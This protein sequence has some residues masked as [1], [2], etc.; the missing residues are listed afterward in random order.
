MSNGKV[1]AFGKLGRLITKRKWVVI[2][3]WLLLLAII[4]PVVVTASGYTSLTFNASTDT[5][6]ESGKANDIIA[7]QFKSAVSNDS[8]ILVVST[9]NASSIETQKF[10]DDL[11]N[12]IKSDSSIT[13]IENV[14][15][16][17]AILIPA[18]NQTNQGVYLAYNNG[19]LTYNLLYAVP[20]VYS[21]VWY[22]AYTTALNDNLVPGLSQTNQGVYQLIPNAN[23]T[24]TL[25]YSVPT[26]YST[27]YANAY[28]QTR[29][30]MLAPGL[31]QANAGVYTA[32]ENANL[33][34]NML[35]STPAIYLNVWGQT[36]A[37]TSDINQANTV[38]NQTTAETLYAADPIS[39][40]MYTSHLLEAFHTYWTTSFSDPGTASWTPQYRA[41]YASNQTNQLY[42]STYL[43]SN[44]TEQAFVTAVTNTFSLEDYLANN[45][46]ATNAKLVGFGI[47]TVTAAS[48]GQS[49]IEFITAAYNLGSNPTNAQLTALAEDLIQ[50]PTAYNM[51]TDFI[52][53]FNDVAFNQTQ[54]ILQ[55]A[56]PTSYAQYTGP[57]LAAF[58]N[59]W[60]LSYQN[61][62][63]QSLTVFERAALVS[64]MTNK[65]YIDTAF[66]SDPTSKAFATALIQNFTLTDFMTNTQAQN[67]AKILD[68]SIKY[69]A[70]QG[71]VS[72]QFVWAAYNLG[73]SP[74]NSALKDLA[75]NI[76]WHPSS[77]GMT[78]DFIST[79][80][81]V[82]YDQTKT[83]LRDADRESFQNYTSHLLDN[84]NSAWAAR[85][86]NTPGSSWINSTAA[87]ASSVANAKFINDYFSDN[88]DFANAVG[89]TFSLQ[90]YL[91][92]NTTKSNAKLYDF[93]IN[94][95]ANE[96]GMSKELLAAVYKLGENAT[97]TSLQTLASNILWNPDAYGIGE[98]LNT[99]V[100][101]FVSPTQ[102]VTLISVS[103]NETNVDNVQ[104]IRNDI[105][106]LLNQDTGAVSSVKVTGEDAISQD[107]M[108]S[109]NSDLDLILPITIA[110]LVIATGLFFRSI[111]TPIV[112]LGTI[113][114]GL[115]VSMVF[116]YLIGT[117]IN[118]V[119]YTTVTVLLTVLIGVGT[120]YSI[121]V[122]ARHREERINGLPLAEAIKKSVTWAGESIVTSGTT[123]IIS[124]LALA[125]TSM[126]MLQTMGLIV[127][128]G[129]I[130]TL[131][132]SLT[133]APALTAILGDRIFWPNSGK[134]F[135]RYSKAI[136][137]KNNR[138]GGYFAKS[139]NFSVKH[140][141]AIILVAIL[142]TVPTFYVYAT[143]TQTFDIIGSAS[144]RL[145]SISGM[146]TL[147]DSFGGGRMLPSYVVVTFSEPILY[148]NGSFNQNEM[149]TLSEISSYIGSH[150]GVDKVT[151]PTMPF[152]VAVDY[153]TITN[154][155]DSTTY[156]S[157]IGAIGSDNSSALITVQFRDDPYTTVAMDY[158]KDIRTYL[159][160]NYDSAADV[161]GIYLGGTTGSI[162][163][164]RNNFD[165][166]FNSILPVVALGVGIVLFFV[167]GSLI[168]P[169][170]AVLSVL[171]SIVWT[172]AAT[173]FVFQS[174]FSYGLLFITPLILF[175]LLLGLGMDYN[176][177]IL[178]RI[179]EEAAKGQKQNDAIVHAIQQTGGI[180]TAAAIILAGS[181]GA[182]ML[183]SN[184]MM[185][186]MGFAFAFSILI[187][188]LVVRTYL[189]PAVMAAFGKWNWYNPIK[190][191]RRVKDE[192]LKANEKAAEN[193]AGQVE[194]EHKPQ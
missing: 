7:N 22:V 184:L 190:R 144:D 10:L 23:Q 167:L 30:T 60:R 146:N 137:E 157:M 127:G 114:I 193:A 90:D 38:A 109:T 112:T 165:N 126:V 89:S 20:T 151:A 155:S 132:A 180:I 102:D 172:L 171:M 104:A 189:V 97:E 1:N 141:K 153:Q 39:Y 6:S 178:T 135:E 29:D 48:A 16:I 78:Q 174:A 74:S 177:F 95:V 54:A 77:Y 17:Y 136:L 53:T 121:F 49:S 128:L 4:V 147:T 85:V 122:I 150:E 164:M 47:Q 117:F 26:A 99:A 5:G 161:T 173:I 154:D 133:V 68:F 186:E 62:S 52:S 134:R 91:T 66:A 19:N 130:V 131:L 3:V 187:D 40:Q 111:V 166:E 124:F 152:G 24:Y 72:T 37:A 162:L 73:S 9:N 59:A 57:L 183:S 170:F 13:G 160:T 181:L 15:S 110:L 83:I 11:V 179:R 76:I 35:F 79:F 2:A 12:K 25:L 14:T 182:L 116:P 28:N 143:T 107:Y 69:V 188:A 31:Q 169:V 50:N 108:N 8:L 82:S 33:T 88:A 56:D 129:V 86:P 176:I 119:D 18:L 36:Y 115:G 103:F 158:A 63:L 42:I 71:G 87:A 149:A 46:T 84:F 21:K 75:N 45:Q 64:S 113:G 192:D 92:A 27:V 142:V 96:S 80:N 175:V 145:E 139:G 65:A 101:S 98:A 58:D 51:G 44:A 100:T 168:L 138:K 185:R 70:G 194:T 93:A 105:A 43:A 32:I 159:H 106:S 125:T 34:Y 41:S 118:Q 123:V 120:D 61:S 148:S 156:S 140:S 163:D 94:Y 81:K 55:A 67:N 191:L